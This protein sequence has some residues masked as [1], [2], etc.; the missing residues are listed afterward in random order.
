[1]KSHN[2]K[3][4]NI[5]Q[6]AKSLKMSVKTMY[7]VADLEMPLRGKVVEAVDTT[8]VLATDHLKGVTFVGV[9]Q[10]SEKDTYSKTLGREIASGRTLKTMMRYLEFG[11]SLVDTRATVVD[12]KSHTIIGTVPSMEIL[13]SIITYMKVLLL[14]KKEAEDAIREP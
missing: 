13:D 1:M 7:M 11:E 14:N 6:R 10:C 9:A 8:V 4:M 3:T 2:W 5:L 12:G